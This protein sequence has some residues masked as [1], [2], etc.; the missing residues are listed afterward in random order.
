MT[1]LA[2]LLLAVACDLLLG[3]P[4][5]WPHPV[6]GI[7]WLYDRLD[8]LAD[9]RGWRSRAYGTCCVAG[10]AV[11]CGGLVWFSCRLPWLGPVCWLY[12]AYAGLA[13][14]GLLA[15][16]GR[17][18]RFLDKKELES[19]RQ[20]V[21]GLVSRDVTDLDA[22]G[23]GRALAESV[24]ENANDGFVAPL[25]YLALGGPGWLWVYKAISTADSMWGY[26]TARYARLGWFGARADDVLAFVPARLTAGAMWLAGGLFGIRRSGFWVNISRDARKSASPNAGWPMAAAAWLCGA[27]MGG[28]ATYFGR[29]VM[30]PTLGPSEGAWD[31][32][33][34]RL[35]RRLVLLSGLIV[36]VL[37]VLVLKCIPG[38]GS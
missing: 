37:I 5:N 29:R 23:L 35:L 20:V 1:E 30:K 3:D 12:F 28:P 7:G 22:A 11:G 2:G 26:R 16:A 34:Q 6:R 4:L 9:R 15:E 17:A 19:A 25:F 32:G 21:A 18:A 14:G 24:A 38:N 27:G 8:A 13:L 10:V 36:V 33:R 31:A